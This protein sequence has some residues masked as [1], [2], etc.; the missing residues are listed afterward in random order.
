MSPPVASVDG[1]G[2]DWRAIVDTLRED[3]IRRP[4]AAWWADT[5][6][7]GDTWLRVSGGPRSRR[8]GRHLAPKECHLGLGYAGASASTLTI[9]GGRRQRPKKPV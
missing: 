2:R 6:T 7:H 9:A 1:P 3:D 5:V 8:R 4:R